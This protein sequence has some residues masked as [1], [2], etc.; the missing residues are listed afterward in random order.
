MNLSP[1]SLPV[2][3]AS[4][5]GIVL[6]LVGLRSAWRAATVAWHLPPIIGETFV[7]GGSLEWTIL[8]CLFVTKWIWIRQLAL[9]EARH[10]V[11]CCFIGLAGVATMLVAISM[12]PY[13]KLPAL[14]LFDAG[15]AFTIAFAIWRT[16][17]L[18]RGGRDPADN[19]PVLYLPG[20]AGCFVTGI[21]SATF[22][23]SEFGQLVF[24]ADLLSWLAIESVL[25]HRLYTAPE[26]PPALRPTMGIQTAPPTVAAVAY[27]SVAAA[28]PDIVSLGLVGYAIVQNLLVA[29]LGRWIFAGGVTASACFTFGATA[30]AAAT[31]RI[32]GVA[33]EN[34]AALLAPG[35]LGIVTAHIGVLFL[36]TVWLLATGRLLAPTAMGPSLLPDD[37]RLAEGRIDP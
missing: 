12:E 31:T 30:L 14:A 6:G 29:R 21:A 10:A 11:Q 22:G 3:P 34:P 33:P 1:N 13:A 36:R 18:W 23:F 25:I 15:A 26:M 19:T 32:A 27:L 9:A 5:F 24:G 16:G 28:P 37:F 2:V 8:I 35:I 7:A 17:Q 4:F 20:V